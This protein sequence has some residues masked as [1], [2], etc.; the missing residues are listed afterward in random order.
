MVKYIIK[1]IIYIFIALYFVVSATFALMHFAPGGPFSDEKQLPPEIIQSLNSFYGFDK[2]WY[3]QYASYLYSVIQWDFGP[4][5]KYKDRTVNEIINEGFPVS[6][7]LG[8]QSL[9]LAVVVGVLIGIIAAVKHNKMQDY[10]AMIIAVLGISVPSFIMSGFLQYFIAYKM[11]LLP[12][13][14]WE[15]FA[16]TILPSIALAFAPIAFIARLTRS[17]MLEVFNQEYVLTAR[18]KGLSESAVVAKHV[19]R[20]AILPVITYL[21]PLAASLITGSFVVEKIFGIPGI[22]MHFVTSISNRDYTIIMGITVFYSI[23]LLF[24]VLIVD[25][26]YALIDPR[27]RYDSKT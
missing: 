12:I 22:G 5:F 3:E 1:R 26:L 4:S 27:I 2:P 19:I 20:N 13:A 8:A 21:G 18:A 14:R 25:I 15:T 11:G 16:H 9:I 7:T 17:N 6:L 24:A 23:L 10:I